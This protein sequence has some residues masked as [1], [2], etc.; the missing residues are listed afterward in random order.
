MD[1]S[2]HPPSGRRHSTQPSRPRH[3]AS[4]NAR[5]GPIPWLQR[6][7]HWLQGPSRRRAARLR[8]RLAASLEETLPRSLRGGA[9]SLAIVEG[10]L[11]LSRA[12]GRFG[13]EEYQLYRACVEQLG[14]AGG[15]L[16]ATSLQEDADP[17]QVQASLAAVEDPLQRRAIARCLALF[18]A[19]DGASSAPERALLRRFLA[20]LDQPE[21][22]DELPLL[23]RR[24]SDPL[25][26][27]QRWRVRLGDWLSRRGRRHRHG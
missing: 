14:L 24:F 25:R 13:E 12:D 22:E 17:A 7:A 23:C 26:P 21:I 5:S 27:D 9:E 11:A 4:W 1:R 8:R 15:E 19:A 20:A 6:L 2:S 3:P 16:G 10:A 18:V